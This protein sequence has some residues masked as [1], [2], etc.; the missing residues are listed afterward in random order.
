M[1]KYDVEVTYT[2][3][4]TYTSPVLTITAKDEDEAEQKALAK[5]EQTG[6]TKEWESDEDS[7]EYECLNVEEVE[8]DDAE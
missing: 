7:G 2:C 4:T 3:T 5:A 8:G 6:P 1:P